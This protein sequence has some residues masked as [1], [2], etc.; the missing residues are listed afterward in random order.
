MNMMVFSDEI[1]GFPASSHT[2]TTPYEIVQNEGE[3]SVAMRVHGAET[4]PLI[5]VKH[6][7]AGTESPPLR[8]DRL[9]SVFSDYTAELDTVLAEWG[10]MYSV[11]EDFGG[12]LF[13]VHRSRQFDASP[14]KRAAELIKFS[15]SATIQRHVPIDNPA[16]IARLEQV[17]QILSRVVTEAENENYPISSQNML[18]ETERLVRWVVEQCANEYD[19]YP[20]E[21]KQI[22]VE[23][24]GGSGRRLSLT[25]DENGGALCIVI[26]DLLARRA[27]YEDSARMLP[28]GFLR[29]AVRDVGERYSIGTPGVA[30]EYVHDG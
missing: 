17:E 21:E 15:P 22:I 11:P 2:H 16:I 24:Y 29:D 18:K 30:L 12:L 1:S 23:V 8:E 10:L 3:W 26:V 7:S 4:V 27:K 5:T 9:G 6:P 13:T 19:V 20:T 25:F 28:D 14:L